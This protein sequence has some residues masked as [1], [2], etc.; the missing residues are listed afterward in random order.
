MNS[1]LEE[2]SLLGEVKKQAFKAEAR[3]YS[4]M[5]FL[6]Y[7]NEDCS[8][9]ADRVDSSLTL[10]WHPYEDK[11][12]GLKLKG[13]LAICQIL[14]DL[15][16]DKSMEPIPVERLLK[17]LKFTLE[18]RAADGLLEKLELERLRERYEKAIKFSTTEHVTA[19]KQ[20]VEV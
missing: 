8:Y 14:N 3:Y 20:L 2:I 19:G 11:L 10:L 18:R 5:D 13:F 16:E 15:L 12:V 4:G 6:L 7:L 1:I 9:R 17:L